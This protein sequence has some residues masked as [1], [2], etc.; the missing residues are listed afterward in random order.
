MIIHALNTS[1]QFK[2]NQSSL[3]NIDPKART[4]YT[5]GKRFIEKIK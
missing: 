3:K 2:K 5:I 1:I 4:N